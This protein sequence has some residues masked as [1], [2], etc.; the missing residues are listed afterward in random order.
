MAKG[1]RPL[2]APSITLRLL[3]TESLD[4]LV[5]DLRAARKVSLRRGGN[6]HVTIHDS[7]DESLGRCHLVVDLTQ[8]ALRK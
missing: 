1:R 8:E 3:T 6:V 7:K 4:R 2:N 5:K